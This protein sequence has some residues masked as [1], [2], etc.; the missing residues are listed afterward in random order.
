[1][2]DGTMHESVKK[3]LQEDIFLEANKEEA[4][5]ISTEK[6]S[7]SWALIKGSGIFLAKAPFV[8]WKYGTVRNFS[9]D[10][11]RSD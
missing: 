1:M 5:L 9:S 8:S 4:S 3:I 10:T 2:K 6:V 7:Q 11:R